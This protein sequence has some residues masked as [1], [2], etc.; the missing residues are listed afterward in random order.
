MLK[1]HLKL[2]MDVCLM[3]GSFA[4]KWL[5]MDVQQVHKHEEVGVAVDDE[6]IAEGE[7]DELIIVLVK[8]KLKNMFTF[9]DLGIDVV[10]EVVLVVVDRYHDHDPD[11]KVNHHEDDLTVR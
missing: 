5:V 6:E 2:W 7:K 8:I 9:K 3:A 1:M 4:Y 10:H 11:L